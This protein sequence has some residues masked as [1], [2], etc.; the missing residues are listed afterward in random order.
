MRDGRGGLVEGVPQHRVPAGDR[1][2][3]QQVAERLAVGI[4]QVFVREVGVLAEHEQRRHAHG[5]EGRR[6][7]RHLGVRRDDGGLRVAV[8]PEPIPVRDEVLAQLLGDE[9]PRRVLQPALLVAALDPLV[10]RRVRAVEACLFGGVQPDVREELDRRVEQDEPL[11]GLRRPRGDLEGDTAA[12]GV[13]EP[14]GG[15]LAEAASTASTWSSTLHGGSRREEPW[16]SRSGAA[17]PS[18]EALGEL[19]EVAAPARDAV[20]ADE[21]P[22]ALLPEPVDVQNQTASSGPETSSARR[23]SASF[24]SDQSTMPSF[25]IRNVPRVGQP[26]SSSKTP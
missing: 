15:R 12:E 5:L 7:A 14:R 22:T 3:V 4:Q 26:R 25:P 11:D 17:P 6:V 16:P 9:L 19:A 20:Q 1:D 13:A 21:P 8:S 24:A 10:E 18:P 2:D 23:V